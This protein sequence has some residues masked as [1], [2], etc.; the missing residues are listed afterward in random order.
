MAQMDHHGILIGHSFFLQI[1]IGGRGLKQKSA[2]GGT[3]NL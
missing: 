2:G 1:A 3:M